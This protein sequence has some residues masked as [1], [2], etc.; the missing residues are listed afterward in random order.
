MGGY[1][2]W[3]AAIRVFAYP[4]IY[5]LPELRPVT[6]PP[7]PPRPIDQT[8]AYRQLMTDLRNQPRLTPVQARALALRYHQTLEGDLGDVLPAS[9]RPGALTITEQITD[10]ELA[11]RRTFIRD[12]LFAGI[13]DPSKAPE[14][15]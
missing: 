11:A 14:A 2:T 3:N 10:S 13:T 8:N 6:V 7:A 12:T 1:G 5:L 15:L 4:E 9:M